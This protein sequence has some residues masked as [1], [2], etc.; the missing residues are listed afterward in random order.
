M[1]IAV[2]AGAAPVFGTTTMTAY[3]YGSNGKESV[4]C[5]IKERINLKMIFSLG[6]C[7][8]L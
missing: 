2:A 1:M 4:Y 3:L 6:Q 7:S 5:L 8:L